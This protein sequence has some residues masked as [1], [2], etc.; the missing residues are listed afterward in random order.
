[1][2]KVGTRWFNA[3]K[4]IKIKTAD[5]NDPVGRVLILYFISIYFLPN[6]SI[7]TRIFLSGIS[8]T[9]I[10]IVTLPPTPSSLIVACRCSGRWVVKHC[11]DDRQPSRYREIS[12]YMCRK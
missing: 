10:N 12:S 8:F 3:L 9:S 7:L 11:L 2:R 6:L 4:P 1:M 5:R